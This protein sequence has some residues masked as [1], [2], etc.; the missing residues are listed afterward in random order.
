MTPGIP[1]ALEPEEW[2][3]RRSGA[4]SI[5]RVAEE[6]HLVVHDPDDQLVSVYGSEELFALMALANAALADGDPRKIT[7]SSVFDVQVAAEYMQRDEHGGVAARL[8]QLA[9][10]LLALLPPARSNTLDD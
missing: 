7:R 10:V 6:T 4:I 8:A 3:R 1:P 2:E 9:D 5:D